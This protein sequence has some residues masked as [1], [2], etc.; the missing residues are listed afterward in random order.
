MREIVKPL[1]QIDGQVR[2]AVG[3]KAWAL[4]YLARHGFPVPKGL[5]VT[6]D[7]YHQFIAFNKLA[8]KIAIE[9][10]RKDLKEMRWEEMWDA[11]LRIRSHINKGRFPAAMYRQL[12]Q[13]V[14]AMLG[15]KPAVVRSSALSEDS[16]NTSYAGIHESYVDVKNAAAV[17]DKIRMVWASLWSDAALLY[18][19]EFGG[20]LGKSGM[21]V[22]VQQ[23]IKGEKSGVA[24]SENPLEPGQMV[25]EAIPGINKNLVDGVTEPQ[26]WILSKRTRKILSYWVP[27]P[28]KKGLFNA[29]SAVLGSKEVNRVAVMVKRAESLF[30]SPQDME[31]TFKKADLVI[32]QSRPITARVKK[33]LSQ[34]SIFDLSLRRSFKDLNR[35]QDKIENDLVPSMTRLRKEL[36][37]AELSSLTDN[38]LAQEIQAR[39]ETVKTWR[40]VYWDYFIPYG[41]GMRLFGQVYNDLIKPSDPYAFVALLNIRRNISTERNDILREM[42]SLAI[43]HRGLFIRLRKCPRSGNKRFDALYADLKNRFSGINSGLENPETLETLLTKI[44]RSKI[45]KKPDRSDRLARLERDYFIHFKAHDR[46][47]ASQLLELGRSSYV[48][49]DDDNVYLA[50]IESQ[51]D[52]AVVEARSRL[53]GGKVGGANRRALRS[54]LSDPR[55]GEMASLPKAAKSGLSAAGGFVVRP[56]Q[57][58][59]QPASQGIAYGRAHVIL[60][61]AALKDFQPGEILV[62]DA[63]GPDMTYVMPMAAGI[64]ERRGGMLIHG[65]I[66]AR[67]YGIPCVTGVPD[68][69]ALIKTGDQVTVDGYFGLVTINRQPIRTT[70]VTHQMNAKG[71]G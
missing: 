52:R 47:F 15:N 10:G 34:R 32:L 71:N 55:L 61:N 8:G 57:M 9:L 37:S 11:S 6:V 56:K 28:R 29:R 49:R 65:A 41:H 45:R 50:G 69:T 38:E 18:Q 24:F 14:D 36:E 13:A 20:P 4:S 64:I 21:A 31:W 60:S 51:L 44:A 40:H 22:I 70:P 46:V 23:F 67:E 17:M 42:A 53:S 16:V 7:A 12:R 63:I 27:G 5:C 33:T 30:K 59:G 26:R 39:M 58:R 66:V 3:G 25:I 2:Q 1:D 54:I 68:A 62:C 48:M 43:K 35:L 19:K